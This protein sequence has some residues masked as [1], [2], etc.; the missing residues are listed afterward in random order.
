M[1]LIHPPHHR[2]VIWA[3][4][5]WPVIMRRA[6]DL[7]QTALPHHRQ[8]RVSMVHQCQSV[9]RAHG[10]DLL[11]KK[12]RSTV[13]WPIFSNRGAS[14]ASLAAASSFPLEDPRA[15]SDAMP[16]SNV[17]RH[18][19]IWL[20]CTPNRLDSSA[21]VPS[22]RTAASATFALNSAPCFLRVFPMSH[23]RPTG[24]SKG[25]LSLNNLSSFRGPPHSWL[26]NYAKR[27][28]AGLRVG[29]S[30]TEGT[31]NFL[32]NRRMNKSQQ[33]RWS[34]RGADLLLQV[35]CAVYNGALGAGFGNLFE[36]VSTSAAIDEGG[37]IPPLSGHSRPPPWHVTGRALPIAAPPLVVPCERRLWHLG[38]TPPTGYT[39][40][41]CDVTR[42]PRCSSTTARSSRYGCGR[43][44]SCAAC[45]A[46]T[47]NQRVA[48]QGSI[49]MWIP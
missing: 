1:Q 15:K 22:S 36:P 25:R 29:T 37:V 30:I 43:Q 23:L 11:R 7:Q 45:V 34:R 44:T 26:V 10:P 21:T 48:N 17:F 6:C 40:L 35:R 20:A 12:S 18:A 32:V 28:R 5:R 3:Y 24:R 16:S 47:L 9:R 49:F 27:Y 42:C 31:A 13:S 39:S 8:H 41:N 19:W 38:R 14:C 2:Q 33:M 46:L 4:R